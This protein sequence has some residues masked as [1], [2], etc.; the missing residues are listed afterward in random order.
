MARLVTAR[1]V[2]Y[3]VD[4]PYPYR[5]EDA[6]R[7]IEKSRRNFKTKKELH[8]A[9]D[10]ASS[11]TLVGIISLQKIDW[12][13][14]NGQISYWLGKKYWNMGIATE[15]IRLIIPYVF[16]ILRFHKIYAN[17]FAPNKASVR[18]LEKNQLRR[19]GELIDSVNKRNRYHNVQLYYRLSHGQ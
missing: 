14:K 3:L 19:E 18:V 12:I 16:N 10:F 11:G 13:N 8:F 2:R 4:V 7:F 1:V 17:V 6:K 5:M 15:S 9:I